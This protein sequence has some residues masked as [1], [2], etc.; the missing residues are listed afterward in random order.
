MGLAGAGITEFSQ[1]PGTGWWLVQAG[2]PGKV[3]V[4][5]TYLLMGVGWG[6][7]GRVERLPAHLPVKIIF[8][9]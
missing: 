7:G 2:T 4:L 9:L 3:Q 1:E 6:L 8:S 5:V